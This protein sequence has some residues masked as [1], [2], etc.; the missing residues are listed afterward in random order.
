MAKLIAPATI[1]F[2]FIGFSFI[3]RTHLDQ[4]ANN[5]LDRIHLV[6]VAQKDR[7][8]CESVWSLIDVEEREQIALII[9]YDGPLTILGHSVVIAG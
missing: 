4:G 8:L 1:F 9:Q 7:T 2:F 3:D 6:V 5:G